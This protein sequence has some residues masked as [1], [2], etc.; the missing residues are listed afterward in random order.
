M[1]AEYKVR[2]TGKMKLFGHDTAD[3]GLDYISKLFESGWVP[4]AAFDC[5]SSPGCIITCVELYQHWKTFMKLQRLAGQQV[6][7]IDHIYSAA[8]CLDSA[9]T[10]F[11]ADEE[12]LYA[13]DPAARPDPMSHA[14]AAHRAEP[15]SHKRG[16][17]LGRV[18]NMC[19]RIMRESGPRCACTSSVCAGGLKGVGV[20]VPVKRHEAQLGAGAFDE[21]TLKAVANPHLGHMGDGERRA[22]AAA[23]R[24]TMFADSNEPVKEVALAA[25]FYLENVSGRPAEGSPW[26]IFMLEVEPLAGAAKEPW[27]VKQH[28]RNIFGD[29]ADSYDQPKSRF[30]VDQLATLVDQRSN[31]LSREACRLGGTAA[32]KQAGLAMGAKA[33][34]AWSKKSEEEQQKN[35]DRRQAA[36]AAKA[37]ARA[38][39]AGVTPPKA[40]GGGILFRALAVNR[41]SLRAL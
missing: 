31:G 21:V 3:D 6:Q 40:A 10:Q 37:S 26:K 2:F 20:A 4:F 30:H 12:A 22:F 28:F 8:G 15:G 13:A 14:E 25:Q 29:G 17:P 27:V 24:G 23:I 35:L 19:R 16:W 5:M 36:R 41:L 32:R 11:R 9:P 1:K 7:D 39:T 34:L 18:K 38:V 33:R